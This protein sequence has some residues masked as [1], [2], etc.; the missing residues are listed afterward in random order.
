MTLTRPTF[1]LLI[2]K[3]TFSNLRTTLI[4]GARMRSTLQE[5]LDG[6]A[7]WAANNN[8]RLNTTKFREMLIPR[9]GRWRTEVP[10]PLVM[11]RVGSLRILGVTIASDLSVSAH[12]DALLNAGARSI[13]Y[14]LRLLRAHGLPDHA[15]KIVARATTINRIQYAG[16]AW[17]GYANAADKGRIQ[18]F[19]ERMFKS[20][21][22]TEQDTDIESQMTA[23]DYNL[24]RAVVRNERHVLRHLFQSEK[25]RI[26]DLRPRAHNFILPVKDDSNF[27]PRVSP[28][29][30]LEYWAYCVFLFISSIYFQTV[31]M[32]PGE[33]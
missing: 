3:I 12:V 31:Y 18:R 24:L 13:L 25:P 6:V 26:Y 17:W 4:V 19:L 11:E 14:A 22:L 8:L 27:V 1:T 16:P 21:F 30:V 9:G 15:L 10:P 5:E 28:L 32:Y 20:G 29:Q 7:H 23:A 33:V 2:Q